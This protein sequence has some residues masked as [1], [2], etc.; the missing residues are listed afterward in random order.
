LKNSSTIYCKAILAQRNFASS[1]FSKI[2]VALPACGEFEYYRQKW[3]S[4]F[5]NAIAP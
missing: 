5:F 2:I 3:L 1:F 4:E